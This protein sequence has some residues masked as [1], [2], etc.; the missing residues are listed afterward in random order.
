MSGKRVG[1]LKIVAIAVVVVLAVI[2]ALPFVLDANQFRPQLESKLTSALGREV[3]LGKLNLSILSGNVGVEDISIA[4][5]P[6]FSHSP[7]VSAKSLKVAVELKPLIFSK[8]IR[9]S[10]ITLD[11]PSIT[12][13]SSKSG[14]W[15][16]SDLGS[17][18]AGSKP[19]TSTGLS[20]TEVLIKQLKIIEG[21]VTVVHA[22]EQRKPSVYS[23]VN[24]PASDLSYTTAFPFSLTASLPGQGTL[25]L[26]GKAGP[27]NNRDMTATPL[28]ADL[29]VKHFDL[30]ASGFVPT[31]SGLTGLFD[32]NG[33]VNSDGRQ[34]R[35][36][37]QASADRLRIMKS[38]SPAGRPVSLQYAVDYDLAQRSGNLSDAAI[39]YG[40]AIAHLTGTYDM[41]EGD[42]VL[43]MTLRG[44][45]MPVQDLT[46]LLPALGITLPKGASLQGGSLTANL[47]TEGPIDKMV[48]AGTVDISK[49]RLTG[50]DLS[51]KMASLATLA[52]LRPSQ[53]TEIEKF[54]SGLRLNP[55]GIQVS[56]L[57]LIVPAMGELSGNGKVAGDQSLD[58][59]MKAMLKPSGGI[60][61]GLTQLVKGGSLNVPFFV[62][63]TAS[64][65]KFVP[66]MKKAAGG[67]LE[68][69]LG[70]GTKEGQTDAGK[71]LGNTL[72]GLFQKKK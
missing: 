47:V 53:D 55:E 45:N 37:G 52:G 8:S 18:G 33:S 41:R 32:F 1:I 11:H 66:D 40:K 25:K 58:F 29:A 65:P 22:G 48:T 10:G 56:N 44:S 2:I 69:A 38:G 12:L 15:N 13:I 7:F 60:G 72:R 21:Q 3:K 28:Q 51:G 70:Q 16:F 27:L 19:S 31:D 42:P 17:G 63:G 49:T 62:R 57:L 46:A 39:G 50:F 68:S 54:A 36:K 30:V 24:I 35:S 20:G 64:D 6:A 4:D 9:I 23:N 5:N 26:D 59:T 61:A 43:K 67:L 14:Q 34:V 71:A